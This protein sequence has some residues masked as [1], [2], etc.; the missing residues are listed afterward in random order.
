[1]HRLS[2]L[3]RIAS[4]DLFGPLTVDQCHDRDHQLALSYAL[5]MPLLTLVF[6]ISIWQDA[7]LGNQLRLTTW[8]LGAAIV[9]PACWNSY[10]FKRHHLTDPFVV[11]TTADYRHWRRLALFK[12][13]SN[14]FSFLVFFIFGMTAAGNLD[15]STLI[16]AVFGS[17]LGSLAMY[18]HLK[19][20]IMLRPK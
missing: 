15:R 3:L 12:T 20:K 14:F 10:L 8:L 11:R 9:I 16:A 4:T 2:H 6:L 19:N 5:M 18:T 13:L 17:T 1:M 7:Q